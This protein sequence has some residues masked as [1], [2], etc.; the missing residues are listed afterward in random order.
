M[1]WH[2]LPLPWRKTLAP[3]FLDATAPFRLLRLPAVGGA[4]PVTAACAAL[5]LGLLA[6]SVRWLSH[7]RTPTSGF[8]KPNPTRCCP[9]GA[10][11]PALFAVLMLAGEFTFWQ[12]AVAATGEMLNLVLRLGL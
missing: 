9:P 11:L 1:D 2:P 3:L 6:D 8:D 12:N 10:F 7:D 5:T 4:E